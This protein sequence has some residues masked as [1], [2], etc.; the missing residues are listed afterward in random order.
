M[1]TVSIAPPSARDRRRAAAFVVLGVCG[2]ALLAVGLLAAV[3]AAAA[4]ATRQF[5]PTAADGLIAAGSTV[6]AD[7]GGIPAVAQ[8]ESSLRE[9]LR[10]ASAAAEADGVR[11]DITSGWR[12]PAYQRWLFEE[13]VS[14]YG[15]AETA[16]RFVASAEDSTHV[17]GRAVDIGS[18]EGQRWLGAEGWRWGLCRVYENEPWHVERA[19]EAGKACP[20]MLPDAAHARR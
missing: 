9:A 6:T 14:T 19:T 3:T 7:D 8:L 12:S 1:D 15:D 11:L 4:I 13:A 18:G 5:S 20:P 16:G 2:V 17:T 10:A